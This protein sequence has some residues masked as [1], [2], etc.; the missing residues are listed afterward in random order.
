V[1]LTVCCPPSVALSEVQTGGQGYCCVDVT[2]TSYTPIAEQ[3]Q[4]E[5]GPAPE[6]ELDAVVDAEAART[7][8]LAKLEQVPRMSNPRSAASLSSS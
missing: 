1:R 5:E 4:E 2:C 7:S 6:P 3:G 8:R